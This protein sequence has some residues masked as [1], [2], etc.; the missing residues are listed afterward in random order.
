MEVGC[1]AAGFTDQIH[2]SL[3]GQDSFQ[4]HSGRGDHI[5]AEN[6]SGALVHISD[7]Q[8]IIHDNDAVGS[9]V[10]NDIGKRLRSF[11]GF[12]QTDL[13]IRLSVENRDRLEP[14]CFISAGAA[15][16]DFHRAG[17]AH[18]D[19]LSADFLFGV[20]RVMR[21]V[22]L[23]DSLHLNRQ[24]PVGNLGQIA[25]DFVDAPLTGE[26]SV[27]EVGKQRTG[28]TSAAAGVD[29]QQAAFQLTAA[30]G[31]Q[32]DPYPLNAVHR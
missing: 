30:D 7:P 24:F 22:L 26:F 5:I 21:A 20:N 8:F 29:F 9:V 1:L 31:F 2:Q 3:I 17:L 4:R 18:R 12:G 23:P 14:A 15:V 25:G 13:G 28:K 16:M 10:K 32:H 11:Q 27:G 19:H 6:M